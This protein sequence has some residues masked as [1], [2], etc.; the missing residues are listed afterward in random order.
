MVSSAD[1]QT[2]GRIQRSERSRGAIV[3]AMVELIGEGELAPTA[4]QVAA[5]ADVGVR[6]VFRH[7]SDM[8]TLYAAMNDVIQ[9]RHAAGFAPGD[10]DADLATRVEGLLAQRF[11][12]LERLAPFIRASDRPRARSA[13]LR[14]QRDRDVRALRKNLL[15]WLPELSDADPAVAHALEMALSFEAWNRLRIDQK[16]SVRK[17]QDAV[18]VLVSALA[19]G[20]ET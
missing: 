8:E 14:E 7:F 12:L 13:F 4:G 20:L 3:Q 15:G 16:L 6:T 11:D 2:D 19:D 10:S 5:R 17:A 1:I 18:R 9:E